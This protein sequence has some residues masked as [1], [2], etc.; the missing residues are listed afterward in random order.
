MAHT[1]KDCGNPN[2]RNVRF[3][4]NCDRNTKPRF[5]V[6][7]KDG[8]EVAWEVWCAEQRERIQYENHV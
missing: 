4:P 3:A 6:T 2:V 7:L 5:L 8:S 1:E